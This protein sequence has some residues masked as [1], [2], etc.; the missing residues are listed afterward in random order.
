MYEET[1]AYF[2]EFHQMPM[3]H[4]SESVV[5]KV[6]EHIEKAKIWIPYDEVKKQYNK[7][8]P[9]IKEFLICIQTQILVTFNKSLKL[10]LSALL[11]ERCY[12]KY[13]EKKG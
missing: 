5:N 7:K 3:G 1:L 12:N 4:K 2:E 6:Y 10:K 13:I 8:K 11:W 9:I